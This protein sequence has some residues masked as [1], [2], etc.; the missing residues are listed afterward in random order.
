MATQTDLQEVWMVV[1]PHN[2]L[3]ERK[4]LADDRTRLHLVHLAIGD[5]FNLKASDIEFYL[6][7]H[8]IPLTLLPI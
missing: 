8:L 1:S 4:G 7:N 2:P 6:P 5:N 3:K